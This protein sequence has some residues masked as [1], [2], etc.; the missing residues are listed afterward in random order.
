[1][2]DHISVSDARELVTP[3]NWRTVEAVLK[4]LL[5]G[6]ELKPIEEMS[7][8]TAKAESA[9]VV[10]LSGLAFVC[11]ERA[12]EAKLAVPQEELEL[13]LFGDES[14]CP[15]CPSKEVTGHDIEVDGRTVRQEM[16]CDACHRRWTDVYFFD[17]VELEE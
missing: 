2:K 7:I 16:T 5:E 12:D 6:L 10:R 9:L 14:R 3:E 4:F 8:E 1:M 15:Y 13:F 17:G 11:G